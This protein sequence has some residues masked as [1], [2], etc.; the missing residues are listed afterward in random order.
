MGKGLCQSERGQGKKKD[1]YPLG[2]QKRAALRE[3]ISTH[4]SYDMLGKHGREAGI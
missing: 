4:E 1:G 3:S 2:L